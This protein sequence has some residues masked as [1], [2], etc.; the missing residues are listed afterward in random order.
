MRAS[1]M[2]DPAKIG[3]K[4]VAA[5]M[6]VGRF[7]V[8]DPWAMPIAASI[9]APRCRNA[10]EIGT[11]QAEQ[12]VI[13][14]PTTRPLNAPA[15]PLLENARLFELGNRKAS[16]RPATRIAKPIPTATN[17]RYVSVKPHHLVKIPV[18]STYSTQKP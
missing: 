3:A 14:V 9:P 1:T 16:V 17:L 10:D 2:R 18:P 11:M 12:R 8:D 13:G 5:M 15:I 4:T 6:M 7:N